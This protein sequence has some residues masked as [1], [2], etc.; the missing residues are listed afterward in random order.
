M[1]TP[2]IKLWLED[3]GEIFGHGNYEILKAIEN[4]GSINESSKQ[5]KMSYKKAWLKKTS[6]EKFLGGDIFISKKGASKDSGT[7]L[8]PKAKAIMN[9]YEQLESELNEFIKKR[10][11]ELFKD[12]LD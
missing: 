11:D 5:L 4:Y 6:T 10:Y 9:A 12:L 7:N 3:N 2:K 8:S 1:K